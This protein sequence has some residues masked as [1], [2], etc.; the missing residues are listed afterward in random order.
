MSEVSA[1]EIANAQ[2]VIGFLSNIDSVS[3]KMLREDIMEVT[4][5]GFTAIIDAE[6]SIIC[7]ELTVLDINEVKANTNILPDF[8]PADCEQ[9]TFT[10]LG[11]YTFFLEENAKSI[12]GKFAM[13]FDGRVVIK[14]N[15]ETENLDANEFESALAWVFGMASSTIEEIEEIIETKVPEEEVN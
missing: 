3:Y 10:L 8:N 5:D 14:E 15:L 11:L 7:I 13:T 6:E 4:C 12:H 2:K 9:C 1:K